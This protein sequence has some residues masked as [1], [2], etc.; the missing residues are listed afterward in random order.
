MSTRPT[1]VAGRFYPADP[2]EL[3]AAVDHYLTLPPPGQSPT[4][5]PPKALVV[6][7]AGYVFSGPVAGAGYAELAQ[8]AGT[9]RRVVLVGP[10]HT[11]G[12]DGVA[13]SATDSWDS[14]LGQVAV[15]SELRD[16]IIGLDGVVV[17]DRPHAEEHCLEVQ[18]PF[19]QRLLEPGFTILPLVVGWASA[20]TVAAVLGEVW[21]GPETLIVISSDL[22]HYHDYAT[23]QRLDAATATAV[24]E[25]RSEAIGPE[26]AC[27]A[28]AIAGLLELDLEGRIIDVSSSGDTAGDKS[29]VVGYGAFAF[30]PR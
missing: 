23:A 16:R 12:F 18:V 1:A 13:L 29:R 5:P 19:L 4:G 20:K 15:D 22:S 10:A 11:V 24:A 7:H 26:Q 25:G 28:F 2:A 9:I 17:D 3:E 27:G 30:T 6:P 21:G 14:P 8:V